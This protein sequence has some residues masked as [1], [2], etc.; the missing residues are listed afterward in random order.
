ML[1]AHEAMA[2]DDAVMKAVKNTFS[3]AGVSC[4]LYAVTGRQE[5]SDEAAASL[6]RFEESVKTFLANE[7]NGENDPSWI[8]LATY[9]FN[10]GAPV[11]P[12][13]PPEGK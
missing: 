3:L 2:K 9:I 10:G 4:D 8:D 6:E 11:A 1:A 13:A 12:A 5:F 7:T